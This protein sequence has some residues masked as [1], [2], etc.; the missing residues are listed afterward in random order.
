MLVSA[1]L[2]LLAVSAAGAKQTATVL[3]GAG[4]TFVSP[5]VSVW[6]PALGAGFDYTIQ[7]AA[8]GSG[9]GIQAIT[10]RSV[11][12]GASDAPLTPDQFSAC[13]GCVQIPWA[14][15]G[16]AVDYNIPGLVVPKNTNLLLTGD[17]IAKI[18]MGQI[19]SWNDAAIKALNPKATIPDQKITPVYRTGNSGTTYNFTDYLASVSPAWKSQLGTG[20]SVNWPAGIG[21]NG[22]AGV[23]GLRLEHAGRPS[24]TP[25]PR[26]RSR[27]TCVSRRSR[28]RPGTSST[29]A[30][31][32]S[33]P[34]EA[35]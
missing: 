32:M 1:A 35:R 33:P 10:N 12:F 23:A 9:G 8:V 11:D 17:V 24:A 29:R 3:N 25:T 6:T 22:N 28:T 15:A 16:T 18:Y 14:L 20:Q 31:G 2:A 26:S 21:A 5:L 13:N 34:R 7:Y 30:S 4:S 27:T 19:T